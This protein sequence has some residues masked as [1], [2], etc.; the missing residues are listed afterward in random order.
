MEKILPPDKTH[1]AELFQLYL[2]CFS[3]GLSAQYID[4]ENL[5]IYLHQFLNTKTS[6]LLIDNS[7]I[8]AAILCSPLKTVENLTKKILDQPFFEKSLYIAE[9]M[10]REDSRGKGLG[11]VLINK[12]INVAK[13]EKYTDIYIRVWDENEP[14]LQLYKKAGFIEVDEMFQ[15]KLKPDTKEEFV[16][17]K[18]YLHLKLTD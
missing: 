7:K 13:N 10:V 15:T 1:E 8:A 2:N 12:A 17:R 4:P 11:K 14:A 3:K 6:L 5:K 9:L 16:M 18:V